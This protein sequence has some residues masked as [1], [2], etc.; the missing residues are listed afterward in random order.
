MNEWSD[1]EGAMRKTLSAAMLIALAAACGSREQPA[2]QQ[3]DNQAAEMQARLKALPETSRDAVFIRAI[4]D[5]GF[6]CQHVET[7]A[8][9]ADAS[10]WTARCDDGTPYVIA[11][12]AGGQAQVTKGEPAGQDKAGG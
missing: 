8:P 12:G 1:E 2:R 5:G 9:I 3:P 11:I 7:S 4:R 10:A 6:D